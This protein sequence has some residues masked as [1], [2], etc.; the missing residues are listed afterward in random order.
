VSTPQAREPRGLPAPLPA[1]ERLLWQGS[2]RWQ[3]L[4]RHAFHVRKLALYFSVLLAA[5]AIASYFSTGSLSEPAIKVLQL[6]ALT[7]V[8]LGILILLAWLSGRTTVYTITSRRVVMQIGIALPVTLNLPFRGIHAAGLR[9]HADGSG[10]ITLALAPAGRIAYMHLWPHARPWRFAHPEPMLRGIDDAAVVGDIL[11]DALAAAP[12][13]AA[14]PVPSAVPVS[15]P[16]PAP[17][18]QAAGHAETPP[19]QPAPARIQRPS[20]AALA[21]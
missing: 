8:A 18:W 10:D 7:G 1:G 3:S 16:A 20:L 4:A 14:M 6:A 2:P 11:A 17:A 12:A 13:A 15:N 19:E 5:S 21:S 9:L